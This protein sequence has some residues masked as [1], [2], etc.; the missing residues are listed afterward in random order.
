MLCF[1]SAGRKQAGQISTQLGRRAR[2][3]QHRTLAERSAEALSR[4]C[5]AL[6]AYRSGGQQRDFDAWRCR[7]AQRKE[8]P[9]ERSH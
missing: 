9:L 1:E 5:I 4:A 8:P 7:A 3:S 6:A 2:R